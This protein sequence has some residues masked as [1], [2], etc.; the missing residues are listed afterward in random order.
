M[1][2]DRLDQVLLNTAAPKPLIMLGP[3]IHNPQVLERY[4][5]QDVLCI[6]NVRDMPE[7]GTVIIRAHGL[8]LEDENSLRNNNLQVVDATC[9]KVKKAQL[10]IARATADGA[11]L[12]LYGEDTH[13]EVRGLISYA[14]G[15]YHVFTQLE[16]VPQNVF[17]QPLVLAAQTTQDF[18][19]FAELTQKLRAISPTCITLD[20]VCNATSLR[21]K[22]AL[23]MTQHIDAMIVVGGFDSGNT[24]R[25]AHITAMANIPT[26]H[27][28]TL[29]DIAPLPPSC[30]CVGLT[31]GASTPSSLI[32]EVQ[33]YL[34]R[35]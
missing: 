3:I 27:I 6:E 29:A 34:E 22:E 28:E 18:T 5:S 8:P 31:A 7:Q 1:A 26:Q 21:Q 25:L 16:Q 10:A 11:T 9:P 2:L 19:E 4:F 14:K 35:L 30:R 17:T 33:A 12:L 20:T 23:A 15:P 32:N 13:P 24:R